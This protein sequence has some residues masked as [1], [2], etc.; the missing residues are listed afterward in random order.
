MPKSAM[1]IVSCRVRMSLGYAGKA[2]RQ[3]ILHAKTRMGANVRGILQ[4]PSPLF[5]GSQRI[6]EPRRRF[7]LPDPVAKPL[8]MTAKFPH[9]QTRWCKPDRVRQARSDDEQVARGCHVRPSEHRHCEEPLT[10]A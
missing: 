7:G 4:L 6:R 3:L 9:S 8:R 2:R 5:A 1:K 10:G